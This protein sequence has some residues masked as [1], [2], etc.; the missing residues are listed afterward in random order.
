MGKHDR[1]RLAAILVAVFLFLLSIGINALAVPGIPPLFTTDTANVSA[2][3]DTPITPIGWTFQ[4]WAVIYTWLIVMH[5]YILSTICRKNANGYVYCSPAVLP[6]GLFVSWSINMAFNCGWLFVWDRGVM[7]A[8]MVFLVLVICTNYA[9]IGFSCH[10]LHV[11]GAWL[12]KY[13]KTELWLIRV[14][15]Q[16]GVAMYTTWTTIATLINLTIVLIYEVNM[17]PTDAA[18]IALSVLSAM[19]L[20]WFILENFVIDKH[21]RYI[22]TIYPVVIWALTGNVVKNYDATS[23]SRSAVFIVVLLALACLLFVIRIVLVIWRHVKQPLYADASPESMSPM[24]IAE[25]QKKIFS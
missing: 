7:I 20:V 22:L 25:K 19:L 15:V 2:V 12:N 16:N 5:G 1:G 18:T 8:A 10:G 6:C 4:I 23:P 9:V 3:F 13:H 21:V 24:E 14:L 11:Y 17:S